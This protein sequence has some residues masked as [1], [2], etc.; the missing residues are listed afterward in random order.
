M[1]G[2][3][4]KSIDGHAF[5]S[6]TSFINDTITLYG[7]QTSAENYVSSDGDNSWVTSSS[8]KYNTIEMKPNYFVTIGTW[9]G[10]LKDFQRGT[11]LENEWY[12]SLAP[13]YNCFS[14]QYSLTCYLTEEQVSILEYCTKSESYWS[15]RKNCSWFAALVWD[16]VTDDDL[17]PIGFWANPNTL[18]K[19]IKQRDNSEYEKSIIATYDALSAGGK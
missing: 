3:S 16:V 17:S 7:V 5:L 1:G 19:N 6:Y 9:A 14:G 12:G 2:G 13:K 4:L 11:Y 8:F 18:I 10:W 15:Y